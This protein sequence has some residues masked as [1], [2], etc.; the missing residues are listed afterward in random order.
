MSEDDFVWIESYTNRAC[1]KCGNKIVPRLLSREET[2][3]R[4]PD[5]WNR[6][7]MRPHLPKELILA[8]CICGWKRP[9]LTLDNPDG[10]LAFRCGDT[11][12]LLEEGEG[13]P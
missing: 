8:A 10:M 11:V 5:P 9:Y 4:L 3:G 6:V 12:E 7:D 2:L 1:P 13:N